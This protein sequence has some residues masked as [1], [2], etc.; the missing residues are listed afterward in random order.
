METIWTY[1]L[2]RYLAAEPNSSRFMPPRETLAIVEPLGLKS[3]PTLYNLLREMEGKDFATLSIGADNIPHVSQ[4]VTDTGL[5]KLS[6]ADAKW[7]QSSAT[8]LSLEYL[9]VQELL[10]R[11]GID[12]SLAQTA[13]VCLT[14]RDDAV[15]RIRQTFRDRRWTNA[16]VEEPRGASADGSIL[17]AGYDALE[18]KRAPASGTGQSD[19]TL[20]VN[21]NLAPNGTIQS[22]SGGDGASLS[23]NATVGADLRSVVQ[24]LRE[25]AGTSADESERDESERDEATA[26]LEVLQGGTSASEVRWRVAGR[27]ARRLIEKTGSH[28]GRQEDLGST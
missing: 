11:S 8:D 3:E 14:G 10:E 13:F 9:R 5:A 18:Q 24:V 28:G 16:I 7:E 23:Q 22:Q 1:L 15:R 17:P 25:I 2:L 26:T 27:T 21:M 19:M 6:T 12:H 20:N 4:Q